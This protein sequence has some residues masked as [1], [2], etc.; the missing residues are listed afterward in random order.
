MRDHERELIA[1]LVEGRLDDESEARALVASSPELQDEYQAQLLAHRAL[2]GAGTVSLTEGERAELHRDVWTAL[3][4]RSEA[5]TRGPWY[6]RA[7]AVAAGLFVVVG[8]AAVLSTSGGPDAGVTGGL[9]ADLDESPT[10]DESQEAAGV[11]ADDSAGSDG[12]ETF[13]DA[14]TTT[15][16]ASEPAAPRDDAIAFYSREAELMR[17]GI[18]SERLRSVPTSEARYGDHQACVEEAGLTEYRVLATLEEPAG[19]STTGDSSMLA[20]AIPV[21]AQLDSAPIAFVD[22]DVCEVVYIDE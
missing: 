14:A 8:L 20:V 3:R 6:L 10:S 13:E 18:F 11:P 15:A 1:A 19:T 22:L 4:H 5:P 2:T 21:D 12:A 7:A 16:A 17:Q 9:A